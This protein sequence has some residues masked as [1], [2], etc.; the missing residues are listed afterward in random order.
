[1]AISFE[2]Y[3]KRRLSGLTPEQAFGGKTASQG[4]SLGKT[5]DNVIPSTA[6]LVGGIA[7]A[8]FHPIRT[9]KGVAS[10]A[11]GGVEKLIPG[12]Q[13]EEQSFDALTDFYKERYGSVDQF[14]T[15][16]QEDPAGVAADASALFGGAGAALRGAGAIAKAENITRVGQAASSLAQKANP[17]SA[18]GSALSV[19]AK[20]TFP[21]LS[22][23]IEKSNLRLTPAVKRNLGT[24]VNEI[25]DFL[26]SKKIVGTPEQR[27]DKAT[28]MY[29]A[30]EDALDTFFGQMAKGTGIRKD[31]VVRG[32]QSLK[33]FYKNDRDSAVIDR[34]IDS[35]VSAIKK[36]QGDIIP[37]KNLNDFK[38]S[39]YKNAYNKA[40]DKVLDD[41]EHSIGDIINSQLIEEL[42]GLK[43][44]G[45]SFDE[46]NRNYGLLI[47]SRK[48]LK[49]AIGK[50]EI[51]GLTERAL[52]ALI[53]SLIGT[54]AG[55]AG[56][57][58]GGAAGFTFAP[59][60]FSNL[61]ITAARSALGAGLQTALTGPTSARGRLLSGVLKN[62]PVPVT[63][64]ERLQEATP[65][66]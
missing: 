20:Q 34:Q 48:L 2:E 19:A 5:I 12:E 31:S 18:T 53:G 35:A 28:T 26:A 51:S 59:A 43:I 66:Q 32:L 7:D 3:K 16:L 15:T 63:L 30:A 40:G 44:D 39:T 11:A 58:S 24:R 50:S 27:F 49:A 9:V 25:T 10:V 45:Q 65:G 55:P 4:F 41:V 47:Q 56:S 37:Y 23:N 33:G 17:I 60:A 52:G 36:N 61:P 46:F 13:A 6:R 22:R 21:W 57:F 64:V 29:N 1:M 62:A 8:L 42:K 38:R 54:T 14:L